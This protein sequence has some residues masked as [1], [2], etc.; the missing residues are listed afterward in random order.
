MLKTAAERGF[1]PAFVL[2]DSWYSG[3]E[4]LKCIDQF[5]WYWFTR[6]KKNRMVNPDDTSNRP[7]ATL[8]IPDDGLVVHMKKYGFMK[9]FHTVSKA[10]KDQYWATNYLAMDRVGRKN[11]QAIGS[12]ENYHQALKELCCVEDCKVREELGQRNHINCS[13]RAYIRLEWHNNEGRLLSIR[14]NGRS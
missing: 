9:V 5:G 2:F 1:Q 4:S 8:T 12:I 10:G 13:L 3:I 14:Q 11:M 7:V 6:V